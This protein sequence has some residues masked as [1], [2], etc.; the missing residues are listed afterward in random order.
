MRLT[1]VIFLTAHLVYPYIQLIGKKRWYFDVRTDFRVWAPGEW[2]L[3]DRGF[4]ED[5]SGIDRGNDVE[6]M[7]EITTR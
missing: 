1:H 5:L 7:E 3:R 2:A 6:S 4:I